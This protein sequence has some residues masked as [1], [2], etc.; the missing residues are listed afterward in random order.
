MRSEFSGGTASAHTKPGT[1]TS[2]LTA[3]F[4]PTRRIVCIFRR[5][6]VAMRTVG[7]SV[8]HSWN[9]VIA[10]YPTTGNITALTARAALAATISFCILGGELM[11]VDTVSFCLLGLIAVPASYIFY[12]RHRF[13]MIRIYALSMGASHPAWALA[14]LVAGVINLK[15]G[16]YFPLMEYVTGAMHSKPFTVHVKSSV[17]A[18]SKWPGPPPAPVRLY[19][20]SRH[21][22][23]ECGKIPSRHSTLL[24]GHCSGLARRFERRVSLPNYNAMRWCYGQL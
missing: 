2:A 16:R 5:K 19:L 15:T 17:P 6:L 1:Y 7:V 23:F 22:A 9:A 13:Q 21:Q 24:Q 12:F 18:P 3:A 11:P 4:C 20:D 14:F 10:S 8:F